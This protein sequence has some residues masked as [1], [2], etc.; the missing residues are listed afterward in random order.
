M[1]IQ[2][3][4]LS[5]RV[6]VRCD[7]HRSKYVCRKHIHHF[8]ELVLV[9]DGK[10]NVT[11]NGKEESATKN[12]FIFLFP[13]QKHEYTSD[14]VSY[15]LIC[16][17]PMSFLLDF[18]TKSSNKLGSR[19]VFDAS[20]LSV[21]LF[22]KKLIEQDTTT[23]YGINA[24]LQ[25]MLDDY[26]AQ[27]ELVESDLDNSTMDK[28]TSYMYTNYKEQLPLS[29]VA[30]TLGYSSNYLSH[31]IFKTLGMNYRSFLGSIRAEH[32]AN[33]L[34]QSDMLIIDIAL[35]CGYPNMRSFQRHF[36]ALTGI[37]PSEYRDQIK[38]S[39][40]GVVKI[41]SFPSRIRKDILI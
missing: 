8:A 41:S 40:T 37:S 27:V 31:C 39:R 35:E 5:V 24:C 34:R 33:M 6:N 29:A 23:V 17:F 25:A 12:Q 18:S 28:L 16:T 26:T 21:E 30:H 14:D 7:I 19:A 13:F 20:Q 22:K 36:K 15:F 3:M 11:V 38:K 1:L 32:A 4:D 9:L 10:L 2:G